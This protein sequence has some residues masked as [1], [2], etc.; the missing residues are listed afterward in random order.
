MGALRKSWGKENLLGQREGEARGCKKG[1]PYM[2]TK[3]KAE[4]TVSV[5]LGIN[6]NAARP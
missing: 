3:T 4:S 2:R 5:V 1:F 6:S